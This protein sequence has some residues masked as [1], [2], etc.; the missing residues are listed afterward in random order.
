[1]TVFAS[2][3]GRRPS[4]ER[5]DLAAWL[6][7]ISPVLVVDG[8]GSGAEFPGAR[9]LRHETSGAPGLP[10]H[11]PDPRRLPVADGAFRAVVLAGVIDEVIDTGAAID[12][13]CRAVA[14]GGLLLVSQ[15]VAP[16]DFEQRAIWNAIAGMR[17]ARHTSTPSPRQYAAMISGLKLEVVREAAWEE[18]ADAPAMLRPGMSERLAAILAAAAARG[19]KDVVRDGAIVAARRA[20]LL[21]RS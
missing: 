18:D 17:E 8:D 20:S 12:D 3:L 14:K 21:R 5:P 6:A 10:F 9:V 7:G 2:I 15:Q 11:F 4:R 16:E 1:V 13:A 19:A